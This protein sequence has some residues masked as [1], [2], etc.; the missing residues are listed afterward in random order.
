MILRYF[1]MGKYRLRFGYLKMNNPELT[2]GVSIYSPNNFIVCV[3]FTRERSWALHLRAYARSIDVPINEF[4]ENNLKL[5][6]RPNKVF[7]KTLAS[8][9]DFLEWIHFLYYKNANPP[10]LRVKEALDSFSGS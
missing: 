3:S 10:L 2:L 6:L 4:L 9:I 1:P 5:S 8:G 7:I